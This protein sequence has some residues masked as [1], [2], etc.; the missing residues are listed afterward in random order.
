[1]NPVST[2][3]KLLSRISSSQAETAD[4]NLKTQT[5]I[6]GA[7]QIPEQDQLR[8]RISLQ[9]ALRA[10]MRIYESELLALLKADKEARSGLEDLA[11][12]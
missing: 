6:L 8:H 7:S 9:A 11:L 5:A 2:L 3:A 12:A 4:L 10:F 1:M